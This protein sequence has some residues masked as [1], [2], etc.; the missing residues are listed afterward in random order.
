MNNENQVYDING[1]FT[2]EENQRDDTSM[3]VPA[4]EYAFTIIRKKIEQVNGVPNKIPP[5]T[6]VAFMLELITPEGN[7]RKW[8]ELHF[9]KKCMWKVHEL[10]V[11]IGHCTPEATAFQIDWNQF[12]ACEGRVQVKVE[13]YTAK[14]GTTKQ[15]N[16]F[17]YLPPA[18][19]QEQEEEPF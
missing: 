10:A 18:T 17:K 12:E 8:D 5:H 16:A 4:G 3:I 9:Y 19:N 6:K 1:T 11:S 2:V 13:D 15:R 7:F 14:D